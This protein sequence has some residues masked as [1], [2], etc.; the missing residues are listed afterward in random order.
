MGLLTFKGGVHPP[1]KKK[2]SEN[3]AIK[4][5]PLPEKVY[6]YTAHSIGAPAKPIVEVG[7]KVKTGQKIAEA[8]GFISAN[9]HSP[10]T[11]TVVEFTKLVNAASGLKSDVIVIE[12]EGE[13]QWELLEKT[14]DHTK[15]KPEEIVARVKEAGIVGLGG[16]M[17]PS[18]VKLSI[19]K[20]KKAESLIINAAE[21]EPYITIDYRMMLEKTSEVLKGIEIIMHTIGVEKAYVGIEDNK[22]KAIS[23]MKE[24]VKNSSI[25]IVPLK[26]KY[27]QGAEKQLINAVTGKEVPSGG[28]PIDIGAV[29]FNVSTAYAIYDAIYNGK[30]LVESGISLTGEGV[31]KPGNFWFRVGTKVSE[32]LDYVGIIEEDKIDRVLYGG[33]MMG[34]SL[35]DTE[36]PTFKGNNA[37]TVM[38][39]DVAP[40][41]ET[42]PCIRCSSCVSVC[43]IGLQPYL[44]KKLA[45]TR[46]YDDLTN[47]NLMDCIECGACSYTC[48]SGIDL[49]KSFKTAKKVVRAM[50]QRRG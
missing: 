41:K 35:P 44:M 7:D 11:G 23:H 33:P 29:V 34:I 2:F 19:P 6:V 4:I 15:L 27:P 30:A 8:G 48:P 42:M 37:I 43:P 1:H 40:N 38:T 17:F 20:G 49:T 45:D 28:L 31:K 14:D 39:K 5:L 3:E 16:A 10:V 47:N 46:K 18:H 21:C 26:T 25:E 13:D 24:A 50:K 12:R 32:L 9:L 22:S 36:L